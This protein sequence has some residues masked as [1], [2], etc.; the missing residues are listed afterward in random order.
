M[1]TITTIM[2]SIL[3]F[4]FTQAQ[5]LID[6]ENFIFPEGKDYDNG[7]DSPNVVNGFFEFP[8]LKFPNSFNQDIG[9]WSGGW[10]ISSVKDSVTPGFMNMYAAR[11]GGAASGDNYAVGQNGA[12]ID[13]FTPNLGMNCDVRIKITNTTYAAIS[14]SEGDMFGKKFGGETG[15][16]PDYFFIRINYLLEDSITFTD[17]FYLADFRFT[18]NSQDYILTE[19]I[20]YER[21]VPATFNKMAFELFSSDT[22]VFNGITFIN[23]P[24]FFAFDDA[25]FNYMPTSVKNLSKKDFKLFPNP[26]K[27]LLTIQIES[28]DAETFQIIDLHG[29]VLRTM[30]IVAQQ[31]VDLHDLAPGIYLIRGKDGRTRRFVKQ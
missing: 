16:D 5:T 17:D 20:T 23:T 6:F 28:Q 2:M 4:S 19:W 13:G 29:R 24:A 18:D 12:H 31:S 22:A 11:P 27:D 25:S 7:Q 8:P 21:L 1:K 15:D 10:A 9:F 3:L 14:M 26:T 30:Q